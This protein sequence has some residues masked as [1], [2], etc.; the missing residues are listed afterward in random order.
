MDS[1]ASGSFTR[2]KGGTK[3]PPF[4]R[5]NS[6]RDSPTTDVTHGIDDCLG[7][8]QTLR[9]EVRVVASGIV[10]ARQHLNRP[11]K[12]RYAPDAERRPVAVFAEHDIAVVT[13]CSLRSFLGP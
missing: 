12:R 8:W 5:D 10:G 6:K 9:C 2:M 7:P 4:L 13:P 11:T 1:C 3:L